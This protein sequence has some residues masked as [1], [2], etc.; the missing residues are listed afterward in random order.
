MERNSTQHGPRTDDRLKQEIDNDLRAT[1]PT[2]AEDWRDPEMPDEE[3]ASELGLDG[4]QRPQP[5]AT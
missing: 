5:P 4:P 3:E 2:R 1:G